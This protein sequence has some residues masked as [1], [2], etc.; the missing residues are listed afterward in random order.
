MILMLKKCK[1]FKEQVI[2]DKIEFKLYHIIVKYTS[3]ML[4]IYFND[5][6]RIC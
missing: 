3:I 6:S 5:Y 4:K 1:T 2:N